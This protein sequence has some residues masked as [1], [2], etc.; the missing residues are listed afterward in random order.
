MI[1]NKQRIIIIGLDGVPFDL[2]KDLSEEGV[3]PCTKQLIARGTFR[4][5]QSS[6]PEISSVA[7][8]SI[9]TGKNPGEHGIFG[10]TDLCPNSYQLRFPNFSD[11]Y[12]SPFWNLFEEKSIIVNIP[13]TYPV[14][15][16]NGIHISGFVSID[17]EKA[18]YPRELI[19]KLRELDYRVD[20]DSN[21][22]HNSIDLFLD[23]LNKTLTA[24]MATY[25]YLWKQPDWNIFTLVFTETDRLMHFLWDAY[26]EKEHRYHNDF[27]NCFRRIDETIGEIS[28]KICEDDL[29]VMLSDHGFERL[30]K[31]VYINYLL[32][33]EGFL[34]L[35]PNKK[36]A[37]EDIDYST[38]AFSLDPARIYINQKGRFPRGSVKDN[39]REKILRN[40][41]ALFDSIEIDHRKVIKNIY[42][43]E[44]VYSGSLLN[45]S[46]DLILVGN[47]GFN[48]KS[49]LGA[50]QLLDKTIFT[51]KHTPDTAFLLLN[52][53]DV[54][55]I[56]S[57]KPE[58]HEVVEIVRRITNE[59]NS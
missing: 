24:R 49:K 14:K 52:R 22:A 12:S 45:Y 46:P 48:L 20:V 8:S 47:Q 31:D 27:L 32:E 23:D 42:R 19:S 34:R 1:R 13:S 6:I 2:I 30:D 7:W 39:D 3:M 56:I 5:M 26:E 16:M 18:V 15:P 40:L 50:E 17:L 4:K 33:K 58:V 21:L 53:S 37:L 38:K 35:E 9:I 29:L 25:K 54:N 28:R 51:G 55:N 41:E 36:A 44:M 11:L 10:F 57:N 59:M 43:K